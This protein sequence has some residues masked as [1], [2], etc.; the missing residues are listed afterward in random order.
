MTVSASEAAILA[1]LA[2][3]AVTAGLCRWCYLDAIAHDAGLIWRVTASL[4]LLGLI[5]WIRFGRPRHKPPA[6]Q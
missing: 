3:L 6:R 5:V 4:P 2:A 1:F